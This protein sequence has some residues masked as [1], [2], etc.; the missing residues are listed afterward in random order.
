[1]PP[2]G[3]K[4]G[5]PAAISRAGWIDLEDEVLRRANQKHEDEDRRWAK[6]SGYFI[7]RD[8]VQCK[9]RWRKT[10]NPAIKRAN[11]DGSGPSSTEK[12]IELNYKELVSESSLVTKV[13]FCLHTHSF[14][15]LS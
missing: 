8:K 9:E 5:F 3:G 11:Q 13:R 6:V 2:I 7:K 4:K 12:D 14:Y 1:M 15:S 10:L